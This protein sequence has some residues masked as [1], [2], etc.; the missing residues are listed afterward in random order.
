MLEN[1]QRKILDEAMR[2]VRMENLRILDEQQKA[3][4]AEIEALKSALAAERERRLAEK[5]ILTCIYAL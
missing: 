1:S 5:V 4:A 3:H 2:T